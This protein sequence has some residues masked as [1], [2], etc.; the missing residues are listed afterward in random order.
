LPGSV[1]PFV[2][3]LLHIVSSGQSL[4]MGATAAP[5]TLQ[6][7]TANRLLTLQDGVRLTNQDDTLTAAMVAPFK[8]L[9]AKTTEVPAVQLA[10]QLNRTRGI[11]SNAGLLVSCHGRGGYAIAALSKGT[12]PYTNSITAV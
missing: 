1:A 9:V 12:L 2:T 3:T 5:T 11:P 7:P 8:P 4:S 6:S 10:A